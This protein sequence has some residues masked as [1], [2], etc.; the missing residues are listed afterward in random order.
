MRLAAIH[1]QARVVDWQRG[2]RLLQQRP[3]FLPA[4]Q[5]S[6]RHAAS[7]PH[8]RQAA[9]ILDPLLQCREQGSR[10][11]MIAIAAALG[12]GRVVYTPILP[13]MEDG[14]G[15]PK[16]Q[17]GLIASANYLGY[18]VG[19]LFT[20]LARLPGR[21]RT[22]LLSALALSALTTGAM[23]VPSSMAAFVG[24]R[25]IGGAAS[26][27]VLVFTSSLVLRHV[28]AARRDRYRSKSTRAT[29]SFSTTW[30]ARVIDWPSATTPS[31]SNAA[32]TR[33]RFPPR[34]PAT[35]A[36]FGKAERARGPGRRRSE[37]SVRRTS[38]RTSRARGRYRGHPQKAPPLE[39]PLP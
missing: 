36:S 33:A 14:L 11:G 23:A 13:F 38:A 6:Q 28:V 2:T 32:S 12:I 39:C 9:R 15:L 18:L 26:A 30:R 19:A 5:F 4:A 10:G 27:F 1:T 20:S 21:E 17:A 25:F 22:W 7:Q 31:T 37:A 3:R 8:D 35:T 34:R 29:L 24:L 16:P